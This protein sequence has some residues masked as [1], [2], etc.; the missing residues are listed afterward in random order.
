MPNYTLTVRATDGSGLYTD[1]TIAV[2]LTNINEAPYSLGD[3]NAAANAYVEGADGATASVLT[4]SAGDPDAGTVLNYS[5]TSDPLG[6]FAINAATGVVTLRSAVNYESTSGS[7]TINVRATDNG[8]PLKSVETSFTFALTDVNEAPTIDSPA[9]GS[10]NENSLGAAFI[11]PIISSD[12]DL[13]NLAFGEA[14]HTVTVSGHGAFET[15]WNASAQRFELWKKDGWSF[16]YEAAQSYALSLRVYDNYGNP[17]LRD[18]YQNFTVNIANVDEAPTAP[19]PFS[20]TVSE[21]WTGAILT[22][23]GSTDPEGHAISY[24]IDATA[25]NGGNAGG[26]FSITPGGVLSLNS[27]VDYENRPAVWANGYAEVAVIATGSGGSSGRQT[28]Y[29]YLG[30]VNDV[31]PSQPGIAAWGTTIFNENTG[32]G[33]TVAYLTANDGDGGLNAVGYFLTS[34]PGGMFTVVGNEVRVAA[35]FDYEAFAYGGSATT[36]TLG[37]A[38]SDGTYTSATTVIGVQIN[39][40]DDN[41]TTLNAPANLYVLENYLGAVTSPGQISASDADGRPIRFDIFGG[42][43]NNAFG[44]DPNTG[45]ISIAA[46]VDY[47]AAGWLQDPA[48]KYTILTIMAAETGWTGQTQV[49]IRDIRVDI[50]NQRKNVITNGS[51]DTNKYRQGSA[52]TRIGIIPQSPLA[53]DGPEQSLQY[54][55]DQ[56]YY[57]EI[58]LEE[59]ETGAI[60]LYL[61]EENTFANQYS[62]PFPHGGWPADGY[63]TVG[64]YPGPYSS[65]SLYSEDEFNAGSWGPVPTY[66]G[67][68]PVVI[69]LTG[70]GFALTAPTLDGL[71]VDYRNDGVLDITGWV[72]PSDAFLVFDRDS[73]GLVRNLDEISFLKDFVGARSDLE[74]LRGF[75]SDG[76]MQLDAEDD[77]FGRFLVWRDFSQDGVGQADEIMTLAQVG[78]VSISLVREDIKQQTPSVLTNFVSATAVYVRADGTTGR[79]GDVALGSIPDPAI[80]RAAASK[81]PVLYRLNPVTGQMIAI[82]NPEFV[83]VALPA[84]LAFDADANGVIDPPSEVFGS[85]AAALAF[86]TNS[87]TLIDAGDARYFDLRVWTD[88]NGNGVAEPAELIGLD[89]SPTPTLELVAIAAAAPVAAAGAPAPSPTQVGASSGTP[90]E[91]APGNAAALADAPD[92]VGPIAADALPALAFANIAAGRKAKHFLI[93]AAGGSLTMAPVKSKGVL[94]P[95]AGALAG[96]TILSFKD[97][98]IGLLA[99]IVLD[100]DGDGITLKS[101]KKSHAGFDMDGDGTRDDTGWIGRRDGLLVIDRNGDGLITGASELSFLT[102]KPDAGSDLEALAMLDENR[103]GKLD[104]ADTR[105]ADLKLWVDADGDG[106]SDAGEVKSLADH[107]I[108]EIGLMGRAVEGKAKPGQNIVLATSTFKRS[109]GSSGTVGDVA[110]AFEPSSKK[111]GATQRTPKTTAPDFVDVRLEALRNSA[112]FDFATGQDRTLRMSSLDQPPA[113]TD[114]TDLHLA[115]MV[116]AM[117]SFG[118]GTSATTMLQRQVGIDSGFNWFAATAA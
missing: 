90:S 43:V 17:G 29:I 68:F 60:V 38:T 82:P 61:A 76:N 79:V 3:S 58:W 25:P 49:P 88:A 40:R 31:A 1:R 53:M 102:E 93:S 108:T 96:A 114:A 116:Q 62:R 39:N 5:I 71:K 101:R 9:S 16:D 118:P 67:N 35:N 92:T 55:S 85:V 77:A 22:V 106:I 104:D 7:Y 84:K 97:K 13:N 36:V 20:A 15:R 8:V 112:T 78:I 95:A 52:A 70:D 45:V 66:G 81:S 54:P 2:A 107:G 115:R 89:Q 11:A 87:D 32:A 24:A 74:G 105:F 109:D 14:G 111:P 65:F 10:I 42:N 23:G 34:N 46:G 50:G 57:N 103:D 63:T 86:D 73:D 26:Y 28:Q 33:V 6:W 44:I 56:R 99:P 80:T 12:P 47:E 19:A 41:V 59:I 4:A 83:D 113:S 110:L 21:N 27:A 30:N 51:Y 64:G 75:D 37:V 18:A 48:G 91:P 72:A 69:D 100:L 94:D 117:A 98:H